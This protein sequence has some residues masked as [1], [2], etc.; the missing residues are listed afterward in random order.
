MDFE[1]AKRRH[2]LKV[3]ISEAIM[4]FTVAVTVIILAFVV[5]GYWINEDFEVER[6]GMLQVASY[7]TGATVAIDGDTSWLQKTTTSK[8]LPVGEH[9]VTLT[10]DGY[11][12]WTK[13]ITVSEG[14][15]YRLQYPRLFPLERNKTTVYDMVGVFQT[16]LSD[17]REKLLIYSGDI[18]NLDIDSLLLRFATS[19]E[20]TGVLPDWTILELKSRK[21]EPKPV[22]QHAFSEF[23]KDQSDDAKEDINDYAIASELIGTEQL[24]FSKFYN[25]HYLTV[26]EDTS[27]ALF[28]K[29]SQEPL[30]EA[31]LTFAPTTIY[32]GQDGEFIDLSAGSQIATIDMESLSLR[33]WSIEN[34]NF[35]WLDDNMIYVVNDGELIV[36]DF[37]GFNRRV[38]A[39]NVSN[40]FPVTIVNDE[41]LYYVSDDNLIRESLRA[42]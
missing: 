20:T 4:F 21:I 12:S 16:F 37:D 14:L 7:P 10:K 28:N 38:L 31:E 17:D 33:E 34:D 26:V 9:T 35:G 3:I 22:D 5:S 11:D 19:T 32:T 6:Q 15:L 27:V 25:E 40:R 29:N 18:N 13:S 8:V 24:I 36:Y 2:N 42:S 39:R 30:L 1:E 41:W 23:F